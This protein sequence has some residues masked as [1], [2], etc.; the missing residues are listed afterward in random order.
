MPMWFMILCLMTTFYCM[1]SYVAQ[2]MYS[3]EHRL[4]PLFL[5]IIGVYNF[6]RI[7]LHLTGDYG[8]FAQL[9]NMLIVILIT[10]IS[11][12]AMDYMHIEVPGFLHLGM[13]LCLDILILLTFLWFETPERYSL[14]FHLFT[15]YNFLFVIVGA[16]YSVHTNHFT[17]R[18]IHAKLLELIAIALPSGV[19]C[20]WKVLSDQHHN[21]LLVACWISCLIILSLIYNDVL[22]EEDALMRQDAFW[23]GSTAQFLLDKHQELLD[24]NEKALAIFIDDEEAR[25]FYDVQKI[26]YANKNAVFFGEENVGEYEYKGRT[27]VC[28]RTPYFRWNRLVGYI[29]TAIDVTEERDKMGRLTRAK[30]NAEWQT[31]MKSRMLA[32][33]SH[34]LRSPVHAIIGASDILLASPDI[35]GKSRSLLSYV[36]TAGTSLLSKVN[37]ILLYSK[38][39]AGRLELTEHEYSFD[40]L[41]AEQMQMLL[42]N[43]HGHDVTCKAVFATPIPQ[44]LI[45]DEE[46]VRQILQNLLSNAIKYTPS[47]SITIRVSCDSI[48]NHMVRMIVCV[49]DTGVGMT[50]EQIDRIFE[51]YRTYAK[52]GQE[53]TGL[54]MTI[55][56]RLAKMMGGDCQV[57]STPG[58]GSKISVSF[59]HRIEETALMHIPDITNDTLVDRI[60]NYKEDATPTYTYPT[61]RVLLADDM[62]INQQILKNMLDPWEITLDVVE[63]GS[64]AIE[65][66]KTGSYDMI[67]L[68]YLMPGVNGLD[69]GAQIRKFSLVPLVLL[70]ASDA[71]DMSAEVAARGMDDFL[72]KPIAMTHLKEILEKN[73]PKAKRVVCAHGAQHPVS[74]HH[75]VYARALQTYLDEMT[76][77]RKELPGYAE[78][79]PELFRAKVH[80]IKSASRQ[81]RKNYAAE[82]AETM[83]MAAIVGNRSYIERHM[84]DLLICMDDAMEETRR[85]LSFLQE[86][87]ASPLPKNAKKRSLE[88]VEIRRM[89]QDLADAFR[90]YDTGNI[91]KILDALESVE[92]TE[93]E[94][95][96]R[97]Q[98]MQY[99]MDF[100]YEDGS[101]YIE[102]TG[103]TL[104]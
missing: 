90:S 101:A 75:E 78:E 8:L 63:D 18:Q 12:Y 71:D 33:L 96:A 2:D 22:V 86:A 34:D 36:R 98:L 97:Q 25:T 94:E 50:K 23:K 103:L 29:V 60:V 38:M 13:F 45:G 37:E 72:G 49:E 15:G 47:G 35:S 91:E 87:L 28:E 56:A 70:T 41:I 20:T 79:D 104:R 100:E 4:L 54:G 64:A 31:M 9:D 19:A 65:A 21:L 24:A 53:G 84:N 55:V 69:A 88:T 40:H 73:L 76:V 92:L 99:F 66:A 10:V 39:E 81:I 61:A 83:E 30:D 48:D 3:R 17:R 80:G 77:L 89:W 7:V 57:Q 68:D 52:E 1:F 59:L 82:Y 32:G 43:L 27:Y 26:L 46:H 95:E 93:D 5:G 74:N 42:Y 6:Y 102:G 58:E 85:E 44:R 51:S 67:F 62:K 11:Y 16:I 14:F